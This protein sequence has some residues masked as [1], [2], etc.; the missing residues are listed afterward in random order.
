[1]Y[2]IMYAIDIAKI[3][4]EPS[5]CPVCTPTFII[6]PVI[7]PTYIECFIDNVN[8]LVWNTKPSHQQEKNLIHKV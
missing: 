7:A 5:L 4:P 6:S 1:M 2:T 3:Y 8:H